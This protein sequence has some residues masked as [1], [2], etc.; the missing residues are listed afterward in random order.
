MVI[1]AG[2]TI[3][4]QALMEYIFYS[5]EHILREARAQLDCLGIAL[6]KTIEPM[7]YISTERFTN[8][9]LEDKNCK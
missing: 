1:L 7:G 9:D 2:M 4:I 8:V 3:E 5:F 6:M